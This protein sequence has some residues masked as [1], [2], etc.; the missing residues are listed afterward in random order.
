MSGRDPSPL[1]ALFAAYWK[2]LDAGAAR[3]AEEYLAR[4]GGAD[5]GVAREFLAFLGGAADAPG[6]ATLGERS[7]DHRG[8]G[9]GECI[10]PYR[11]VKE[12]GRGGQGAVYLAVDVRVKREV[13]LKVL[14]ARTDLSPVALERFR[15]EAAIASML[16]HPGICPV[17]DVGFEGATP[18]LAMKF[19]HGETLADKLAAASGSPETETEVF[20]FVLLLEQVARALHAAHEAGV[21]H[22]DVKPGNIMVT[23]QGEPAVLDFGLA[24]DLEGGQPTLTQIGDLMGTPAYMSPEQIAAQRIRLDRRTD[25]YSL[26]VTLY[27][28][29]TL[30]RPFEAPTR[31]GLYQSILTKDPAVLSSVNPA[32]STDLRVVV[33]TAMEKDR[34]RRYATALDLAEELRRVRTHEPI[35]AKP[36]G[37]LSRLRRWMQRNPSLAVALIG[38][39]VALAAGL[40]VALVLLDRVSSE[41]NAKQAALG[42]YDRLG[43]VSR[44][45]RLKVEAGTLWPSEPEKVAAMRAWLAEAERLERTLPA[46]RAILDDLRAASRPTGRFPNEAAQFK[47]DTTAKLTE[48]LAEFAD[49]KP[50]RGALASVR[51]R[52]RFAE[53]VDGETLGRHAARWAEA[54]HAVADPQGTYRGF[55]LAPQR[56]LVPI[57]IDPKS[58]LWEFAD[59]ATTAEGF[60]PV[61]GRRADG[62]LDVKEQSG[63]VFV[64]LPGG[65][66]Q[67]GSRPPTTEESEDA[68][69]GEP[70]P[71]NVDPGARED[72]VPLH[73]V[74]LAPFF[75]SKYELTQA[76]WLRLVGANPAQFFAGR[77]FGGRM[78]TPLHPVEQVHGDDCERVLGRLGLLLPTEAQWEYACRAGTTTPYWTGVAKETLVAGAN[79]GDVSYRNAGGWGV[80]DRW[81]DGF[82]VHAPIGSSAPNAFGLHDTLGNVWEWCADWLNDYA[83]DNWRASDGLRDPGVGGDRLRILRG[84]SFSLDASFA[85]CAGRN[86]LPPN[87]GSGVTGVRPARRVTTVL[88]N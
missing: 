23:P 48:D 61:P 46:H 84:G 56:G 9:G 30:H 55:R 75:M 80:L 43:D 45:A 35:L 85:R 13:A 6:R 20:R 81:N 76:Q 66:F 8:A 12:I 57:G 70:L 71:D 53:L 69:A 39:F 83:P 37:P 18:Y 67:M 16:D 50:H 29:L 14:T 74:T 52:L 49:P 10:G 7:R 21:I 41:R 82:P 79:T 51:K 42:D 26:G 19:V 4:Y 47:H 34:D 68:A 63:L 31:E 59:L 54:E 1:E 38:I 15:R 32:V 86:N 5:V 2:D 87:S 58:G 44:L 88:R 28:C 22:R 36:V 33:E 77:E 65:T 11:I 73:M 60:D 24:Q 78:T 40:V 27:E 3:P 62:R 17:Y 25:V 64:L 72:E